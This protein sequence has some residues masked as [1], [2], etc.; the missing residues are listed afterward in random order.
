MI[1]LRFAVMNHFSEL[2]SDKSLI[3]LRGDKSLIALR[4]S[5]A[6]L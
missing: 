2:R 4:A 3:A 6:S 5:F 1:L